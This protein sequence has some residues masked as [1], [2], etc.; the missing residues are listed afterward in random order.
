MSVTDSASVCSV[1]AA[2]YTVPTDLPEADGTLSWDATT[3]VVVE[4]AAADEVGLGWSYTVN[5]TDRLASEALVRVHMAM[6]NESG[7][8]P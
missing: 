7:G 8:K 1:E 5:H 3:V 6:T 4:V 2:A